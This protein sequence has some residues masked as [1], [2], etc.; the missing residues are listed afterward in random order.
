M[1]AARLAELLNTAEAKAI[2]RRAEIAATAARKI[3]IDRNRAYTFHA[4]P[5]FSFG[6]GWY[7][8]AASLLAGVPIQIRP[9]A[10]QE[11][12]AKRFLHDAGLEGSLRPYRSRPASPKHLT[13]IIAEAFH[14]DA[15]SSQSTLRAAFLGNESPS[16]SLSAWI[17]GNVGENSE[18]KVLLWVR[19]GDHDAQR[20]TC[21]EELRQLSEL[22]LNAG[23]TPIFFGD[24][25][26]KVLFR[27]G[28]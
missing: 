22:I 5:G 17:D 8:A 4:D 15:Q 10:A 23:L 20:N 9:G 11:L 3:V 12:Q 16:A 7:L 26:P 2:A 13:H 21:F 28:E 18:Q 19:T 14:T 25:V 1:G 24:A 27:Q 6:E